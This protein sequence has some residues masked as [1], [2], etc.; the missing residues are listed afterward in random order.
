M[1]HE[2]EFHMAGQKV[3]INKEVKHQQNPNF[4]GSNFIIEDWWDR[5]SGKSWMECGSNPAAFVYMLRSLESE[6]ILP[7][8][9]EVVYGKTDD[10]LGH[11]V[12]ISELDI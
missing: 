12:H 9:D 3:K 1:L 4:G 11:I 6:R 10:G 5:V 2:K 8:D 7:M